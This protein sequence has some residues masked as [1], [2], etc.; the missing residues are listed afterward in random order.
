MPRA[1]TASERTGPGAVIGDSLTGVGSSVD[2]NASYGTGR[3]ARPA[4]A[5]V[6]KECTPVGQRMIRT[7]A[8]SSSNQQA[9]SAEAGAQS[10]CFSNMLKRGDDHLR[11]A[12]IRTLALQLTCQI[13]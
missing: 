10:P 12:L 11:S 3:R 6:S 4:T 7:S 1:S 9:G 2:G 8:P 5:P 13:L